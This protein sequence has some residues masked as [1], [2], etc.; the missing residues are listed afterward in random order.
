M[1]GSEYQKAID[2]L[3]MTQIASAKLLGVNET[4]PRKWIAETHPI[5]RAVAMVLKLMLREHLT[6]QDMMNLLRSKL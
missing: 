5:P 6:E 2:K 1:T 3:G 4:T